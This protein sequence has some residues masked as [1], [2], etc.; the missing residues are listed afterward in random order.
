[1]HHPV[2]EQ[3][4]FIPNPIFEIFSDSV[5][6]GFSVCGV[7]LVAAGV[8]PR[9]EVLVLSSLAYV[10]SEGCKDWLAE[11]RYEQEEAREIWEHKMS[12][13]M[14]VQEFV[15][16]AVNHGVPEDEAIELGRRFVQY[17]Q[18]SVPYH[19]EIEIGLHKSALHKNMAYAMLARTTGL[20]TGSFGASVAVYLS[21]GSTKPQTCFALTGLLVGSALAL[22]LGYSRSVK[23]SS[24]VYIA[25]GV[26]F[27]T[28]LSLASIKWY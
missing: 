25:S 13:F 22:K 20:L 23:R 19:L 18:I 27:A 15:D 8:L 11:M 16:Y 6:S 5:I 2:Q 17:P 1:M 26:C 21:K 14:E 24:K 28:L 9:P 10:C 3:G 4:H 7:G 12:P